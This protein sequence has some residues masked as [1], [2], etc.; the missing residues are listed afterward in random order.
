MPAVRVEIPAEASDLGILAFIAKSLP[1]PF[2]V[3][4]KR[5]DG[6]FE[7]A[8]EGEKNAAKLRKKLAQMIVESGDPP[9]PE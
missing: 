4:T 9:C 1:G 5:A 2:Y 6:S 3:G 7:V 8:V